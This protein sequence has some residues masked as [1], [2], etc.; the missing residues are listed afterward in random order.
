MGLITGAKILR[1][2]MKRADG[3][4]EEIDGRQTGSTT[5]TGSIRRQATGGK[6][7]Q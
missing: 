4:G 2:D 1:V 6:T 7:M 3:A 5:V